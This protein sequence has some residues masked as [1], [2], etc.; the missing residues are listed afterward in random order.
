MLSYVCELYQVLVPSIKKRE[1]VCF[2]FLIFFIY[3]F[4]HR[5][6]FTEVYV[7]IVNVYCKLHAILKILFFRLGQKLQIC[8]SPMTF[9]NVTFEG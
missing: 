9:Q 2:H 4:A 3:F 1:F 7:R 8:K 5:A 6:K